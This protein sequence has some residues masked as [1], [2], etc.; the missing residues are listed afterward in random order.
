MNRCSTYVAPS[1]PA[2][3]IHAGSGILVSAVMCTDQVAVQTCTIYDNTACS[4]TVLMVL[5][6]AA[7][8][9]MVVQF[10]MDV[11][12]RFATGL[13]CN[14]GNADVHLVTLA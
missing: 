11:A 8:N 6:A 14:P 4:G 7:G 12:P 10:R 5:K 2:A 1:T 3:G 13:S 9:P